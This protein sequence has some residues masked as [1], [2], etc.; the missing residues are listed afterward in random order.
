MAK[1]G[2][3]PTRETGRRP[4]WGNAR[5]GD[6][7][8]A[9]RR[10]STGVSYTSISARPA[11]C[12]YLHH[13]RH[14]RFQHIVLCKELQHR[15]EVADRRI[16]V[17]FP[18]VTGIKRK[19]ADTFHIIDHRLCQRFSRWG[20]FLEIRQRFATYAETALG[21]AADIVVKLLENDFLE[22]LQFTAFVGV[23]IVIEIF[24]CFF[25]SIVQLHHHLNDLELIQGVQMFLQSCF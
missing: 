6:C 5:F 1:I 3:I 14:H 10:V 2:N 21:I 7:R 23:D 16:I 8:D 17:L 11:P 20:K 22:L 25:S 15:A 24:P 4:R 19:L 13:A 12:H 9:A 18:Q